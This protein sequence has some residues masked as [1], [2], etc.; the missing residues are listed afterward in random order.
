MIAR[1]DK[2]TNQQ[3]LIVL[4]LPEWLA[5]LIQVKQ[6]LQKLAM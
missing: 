3:G 4:K 6:H 5:R 1:M 2:L